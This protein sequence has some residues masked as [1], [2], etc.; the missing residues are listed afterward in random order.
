MKCNKCGFENNDNAKFCSWC[1]EKI[2]IEEEK[3]EEN[4][5]PICGSANTADAK[6]CAVCGSQMSAKVAA[7]ENK[8]YICGTVNKADAKY[9]AVCGSQMISKVVTQEPVYQQTN[10]KK[11]QSEDKFGTSSMVVGIVALAT[12]VVCCMFPLG[13]FGGIASVIFG[14][15]SIKRQG[16]GTG[17]ALAG[18]ICGGIAFALG[19][20]IT[21][22]FIAASALNPI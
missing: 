5:C 4:K 3:K 14:A 22:A 21:I 15:I 12:T 20:I 16:G 13:I 8:C 1:G 10:N 19:L 11:V 2:I 17:K 9:C 18:L 7:E 6:Y